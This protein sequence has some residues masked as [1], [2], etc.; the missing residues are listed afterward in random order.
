MSGYKALGR[1]VEVTAG[2][3]SQL[4]VSSPECFGRSVPAQ[5]YQNSWIPTAVPKLFLFLGFIFF[6]VFV[7]VVGKAVEVIGEVVEQISE[8]VEVTAGPKSQLFW[9]VNEI[10]T[11]QLFVSS[12]ECFGR[13]ALIGTKSRGFQLRCRKLPAF[14]IYFCS[15]FC[16]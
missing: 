5:W 15:C 4:F 6:P 1:A 11:S 12:P 7:K 10:K 8:L 13:S 2:P 3:M 14:E 16:T 9:K